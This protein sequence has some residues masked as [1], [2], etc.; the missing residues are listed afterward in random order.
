M[1]DNLGSRSKTIPVRAFWTCFL[2]GAALLLMMSCGDQTAQDADALDGVR[3][4]IQA[5]KS[6]LARSEEIG[7]ESSEKL[8]AR[9]ED[10]SEK[11]GALSESNAALRQ[12]IQ[13]LSSEIETARIREDTSPGDTA[14]PAFTLQL[15]HASDMDSSV[16]ALDNVE[17]F[18]AILNGFRAQFPHNTLVVSSGDNYIPGPRYYAA[19]DGSTRR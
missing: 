13:S 9:V 19:G 4:D 1:L 14:E 17:N 2:V 7:N 6:E 18:S 8:T 11:L 15:L 5:L 3:Q 12:E 10:L 16:G